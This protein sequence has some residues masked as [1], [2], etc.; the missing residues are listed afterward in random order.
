MARELDEKA[1][2]IHRGKSMD[3]LEKQ[4]RFRPKPLCTEETEGMIDAL[5]A[6]AATMMCAARGKSFGMNAEV[7][8]SISICGYET[9]QEK[10]REIT[11][12]SN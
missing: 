4:M 3:W 7:W 11:A 9:M 8:H 6:Y 12:E 2:A 5:L 10:I 1:V